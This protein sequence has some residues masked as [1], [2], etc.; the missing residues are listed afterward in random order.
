[1][2]EVDAV[3]VMIPLLPSEVT[4]MAVAGNLGQ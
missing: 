4:E 2:T 1:M 3:V